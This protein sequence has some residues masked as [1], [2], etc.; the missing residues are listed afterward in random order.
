MY[1]KITPLLHKKALFLFAVCANSRIF[2]SSKQN[3]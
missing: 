3:N 2:A 1:V